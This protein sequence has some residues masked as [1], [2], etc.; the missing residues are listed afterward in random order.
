[1]A[2]QQTIR[3]LLMWVQNNIVMDLFI[4]GILLLTG[5]QHLL[6]PQ[7]SLVAELLGSWTGGMVLTAIAVLAGVGVTLRGLAMLA[8][9]LGF[10]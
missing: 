9:A 5:G 6:S 1:M 4:G 3:M 10:N 7:Q 8:R 2:L